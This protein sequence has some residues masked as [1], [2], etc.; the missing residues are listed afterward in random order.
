MKGNREGGTLT[1]KSTNQKKAKKKQREEAKC[2]FC[3]LVLFFSY[4]RGL[5]AR[6]FFSSLVIAMI[7]T[8]SSTIRERLN[9]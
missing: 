9:G 4:S 1:V 3:A 7:V 6:S 2:I 5:V 8:L